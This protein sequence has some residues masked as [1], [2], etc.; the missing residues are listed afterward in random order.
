MK[1]VKVIC[2]L[3]DFNGDAIL[4]QKGNAFFVVST[5]MAPDWGG[6]ETLVFPYNKDKRGVSCWLEICGGRGITQQEALEQLDNLSEAHI[7]EYL[8]DNKD[9]METL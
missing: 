9:F 2:G 1:T 4:A 6:M 5:I 3:D 7:I 8:K